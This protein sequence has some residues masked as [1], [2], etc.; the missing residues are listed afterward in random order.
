[1]RTIHAF[2]A[3]IVINSAAF[4]QNIA[5]PKYEVSSVKP[6]SD[7]EFHYAFRVGSDGSLYATGITLR[8]LMMTAYDAQGFRFIGGPSWVS[9]MQWDVQA[10]PSR[11][12]ADKEIRPMLRSLLED[13][14]QL[15][16]HSE[17]RN[18]PVYEL[19]VSPKGS[20][21]QTADNSKVKPDI[22]TGNGFIRFTRATVATFASQLSYA[23][24]R[25]VIDETGISGEFNFDLEWTPLPGED[26]GP[27]SS[28]L[29]VGTPVQPA[30]TPDGLSV[31]TAIEEQL[32]F[33][34]KS[35]RGPGQVIVID[36]AQ[37]P[38][39]N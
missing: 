33:H 17:T 35:G 34:L 36:S 27:A 24:A 22:R 9:D 39:A 2:G 3:L 8:R 25:P 10:K 15:R 37:K 16:V 7:G 19:T 12:A 20:K 5:P 4:G 13:R 14:F 1:V 31:F 23:L 38:S 29:P 32:G 26:G 6:N 11:P 21:L 18:M 30:P 28:G